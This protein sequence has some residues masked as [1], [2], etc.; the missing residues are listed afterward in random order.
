MIGIDLVE[1]ERIKS[2]IKSSPKFVEKIL[3]VSEQEY[4]NGLK[5][6]VCHIAG[7]FACKEAVMKALENC[8]KIGF[9]EIEIIHKLSG[10]PYV[11]LYGNAKI[12]FE[13][14]LNLRYSF[15]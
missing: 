11:K 13:K 7:F 2:A 3:T 4:V 8:K 15:F 5:N 1:V 12:V 10:K 9:T 14:L 6:N